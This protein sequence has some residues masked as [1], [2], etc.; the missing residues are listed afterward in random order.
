MGIHFEVFRL[1]TSICGEMVNKPKEVLNK[2]MDKVNESLEE[3]QEVI[4]KMSADAPTAAAP[5]TEVRQSAANDGSHIYAANT[6]GFGRT[7]ADAEMPATNM[8]ARY[9]TTEFVALGTVSAP[10]RESTAVRTT[11]GDSAF[12]STRTSY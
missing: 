1:L 11:R 5:P 7:K 2:R 10:E 9:Q 8:N 6:Q 12:S 4:A 3:V